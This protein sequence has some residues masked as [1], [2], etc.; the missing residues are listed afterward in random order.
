MRIWLRISCVEMINR[1]DAF[2]LTTGDRFVLHELN[3]GPKR[4]YIKDG[5]RKT[6]EHGSRFPGRHV[7]ANEIL[8]ALEGISVSGAAGGE[9]KAK[10]LSGPDA[11]EEVVVHTNH[12]WPF[13]A[14]VGASNKEAEAEA[15]RQAAMLEFVSDEAPLEAE[16]RAE[17]VAP[18]YNENAAK[19]PT[20]VSVN[21]DLLDKAKRLGINL[22]QAL[23]SRLAELVAARLREQWLEE[24][25]GAIEAYNRRIEKS[26]AF[27]DDVRTF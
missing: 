12:V 20:N 19:R 17:L 22:S 27:G 10:F 6:G 1:K 21:S 2:E 24:N 26:G 15:R 4:L 5:V 18:V 13:C 8:E 14:Y 16:P 23:E 25:E 3:R 11:G 9:L 7:G